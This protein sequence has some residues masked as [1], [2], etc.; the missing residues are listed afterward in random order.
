MVSNCGFPFR[1]QFEVVSLWAKHFVSML[2][3]ELI[4]EFYTTNGKMLRS[5]DNA[6]K[7]LAERYI[8]YL[9]KCGQSIKDKG[10]LLKELENQLT[11]TITEF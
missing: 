3:G 8:E 5:T 1:Q 9:C 10:K 4:C 6:E 11:K 2:N 7:A